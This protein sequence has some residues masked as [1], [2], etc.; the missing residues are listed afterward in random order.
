MMGVNLLAVIVCA[1][2]SMVIGSLWY[3]PLFGKKWMKL[4]SFTKE[5]I[6]KGKKEMPKTYGMMF[7][8]SIVTSF[9]LAVVISMAP[10]PSVMTGI[11]GAFWLWLGFIVAPKL[12][13]VLFEKKAWELFY[14]ECGY[15]LVFLAVAGGIL[16][17]WM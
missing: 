7:V 17:S 13:E 1:V 12:S 16:G 11:T 6:E 5:E 9:V 14:I 10:E 15:Y 3:G 4:L 8:G 2:L